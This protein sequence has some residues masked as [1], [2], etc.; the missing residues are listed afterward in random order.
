MKGL[1]ITFEGTEGSGKSTQIAL[2]E[3][4]L[5]AA[6]HVVQMLREPGG[7]PIGEEIRHTLKH[8]EFNR[9][10]K[11]ETELLLMN[12][13]RAQ[14]VREVIRPALDAGEV[15]LC[16]RFY[17]STL[18][19]QGYGRGLDLKWVQT[20]VDFAVGDIRPDITLL[21]TVP[22]SISEAR[23][24]ARQPLLISVPATKSPRTP[25]LGFIRDRMEEADRAFFERVEE[26]YQAI[27]GADKKRIKPIDGT[28]SVDKVTEEIWAQVSRLL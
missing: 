27:A 24:L 6:G 12:A 10:M 19:Y 15:V 3:E 8:S 26:G 20:I 9:G 16:D 25:K 23:R 21:L 11:P 22:V 1:F 28:Q 18:A 7:T 14:L 2:L 5:L 13:A 4:R 17:D